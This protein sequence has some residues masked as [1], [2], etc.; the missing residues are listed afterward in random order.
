M[1]SSST[2]PTSSSSSSKNVFDI[3]NH[4]I[5]LIKI[6]PKISNKSGSVCFPPK[7]LLIGTPSESGVFPVLILL[8]GYLLYNSFYSQLIKHIASHGFIVV[9]PQLYIVTGPDANE[10][11]K[12][13]ADITN[14]LSKGLCHFLPSN[15]RPNL[16]KLGLAGHSR[17][18]KV[19]FA[20]ALRKQVTSL[21]FSALIGIDPVDG[22]DKGKQTPPP[23]LNYVPHSFDL[24]HMAVMVIGSGLG[25][26]KRNPLFPP[27]APRGVNHRDFFNECQKPA[28]YFVV[29]DYGHLDMLDDETKG[30]RGN[31]TRCLCK[32]GES[33]EPMRRFVGGIVIAFM[34]A[35]LEGNSRELMAI[36][37]GSEIL[38][39][40]LQISEFLV[41][42]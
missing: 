41:E 7:P 42:E 40:E 2:I 13:T 27:C 36:R 8:H 5:K 25:E 11:I 35:Y 31:T 18:G 33:R 14:W 23:V 28:I 16:T 32:N 39:V 17:G 19:A 37:D 4:L 21:K 38:P 9:A 22:M 34:K 24:D 3:G 12:I 20:L 30:F 29:K 15:V 26:I 1:N 6:E 10:E